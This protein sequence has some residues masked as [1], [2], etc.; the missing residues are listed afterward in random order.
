MQHDI[1][2]NVSQY[3]KR[4]STLCFVIACATT[5]S[6]HAQLH[7]A[8][9]RPTSRDLGQW[10]G[11]ARKCVAIGVGAGGAE[12]AKAPPGLTKRGRIE[13]NLCTFN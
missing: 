13:F 4:N 3:Y 10:R 6:D 1:S 7:C 2:N 11:S 9:N 8:H 12:G 5:T